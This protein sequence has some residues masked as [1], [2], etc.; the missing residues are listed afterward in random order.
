MKAFGLSFR[1]SENQLFSCGNGGNIQYSDGNEE[2]TKLFRIINSVNDLSSTSCELQSV[3]NSWAQ[4]YHLSMHRG[5]IVRSLPLAANSRVFELGAGCGA[6]TR[7]LGEKFAAVDAVEGSAVRARICA[8]RCRDL[9][10]VRVF[11]ADINNI[12]PQPDYDIAFLVG[13]LEWSKGYIQFNDPFRFCLQIAFRA[14]KQG[15]VLVLA[16]ENQIGTL[17]LFGSQLRGPKLRLV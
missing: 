2:E 8:S 3:I 9:P 17:N 7:A 6:V 15:G 1:P 14:L 13:V 11:A 4:R 10:N 12:L 16:I 5:A